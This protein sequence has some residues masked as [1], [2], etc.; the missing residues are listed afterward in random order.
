M[1]CFFDNFSRLLIDYSTYVAR[2]ITN[3]NRLPAG[4]SNS[5]EH[6]Y[7]SAAYQRAFAGGRAA[8][9]LGDAKE[10]GVLD[11]FLNEFIAGSVITDVDAERF[12]SI[13]D[14]YNNS[15][16]RQ[17]S[18]WAIENSDGSVD[19]I[20]RL[21]V[22]AYNRGGLIVERGGLF[23]RDFKQ[24]DGSYVSIKIDMDGIQLDSS[25]RPMAVY[26]G[27][28][29]LPGSSSDD[30]MPPDFDG[31]PNPRESL[32]RLIDCLTEPLRGFRNWL[33]DLFG[34]IFFKIDPLLLDLDLGGVSLT[35][36]SGS[37]VYFDLDSN[38]FAERTGWVSAGEGLLALDGNRNG[39]ID[40]GNELFGG[41]TQ[42]GFAALARY[43]ENKDGR[44][45]A[46]DSVW[47][48]LLIWRDANGDGVST[49]AELT[50]IA[51][52]DIGSIS[53]ANRVPRSY[54][55]FVPTR[56]GNQLLGIG[57]YSSATGVS[58][59][60]IA[61]GFNRDLSN[62][63][64]VLPDG[65]EYDPEVFSLP[66]L[67]GY[68]SLPD[69]W[70]AM[71]LDP[72]LKAMV[73]DLMAGNYDDISDLVGRTFAVDEP[74]Y[75]RY[76]F[77][78]D[79]G[80]SY[81]YE[82]SGFDN[83]LARWAGVPTNNVPFDEGQMRL[84]AERMLGRSFEDSNRLFRDI[85]GS[86][87]FHRA[88]Q[89]MSRELATRF[90]VGMAD[91]AENGSALTLFQDLLS[92]AGDGNAP[93]DPAILQ[94]LIDNAVVGAQNPPTLSPFLAQY[95]LLDYDFGT[96][97]I[98]GDIAGY[99]DAE[100]QAFNFDPD[101]SDERQVSK[102]LSWYNARGGVFRLIDP[103]GSILDER[104]RV[105]TGN[106]YLSVFAAAHTT[107]SGTAGND[108]I[109]GAVRVFLD[110][111]PQTASNVII[112]G[113]GNDLLLGGAG[114]DA[115]VFSDG[116]GQDSVAD[117]SGGA[118]E[119]AFQGSLVSSLAQLSY[120]GTGRRDLLITFAGRTESVLI[121]G[122]FDAAGNATIERITFPDG[123]LWDGQFVRSRLLTQM[124]TAGDDVIRG[125][126]GAETISGGA[127][128]DIL[129]Y[130]TSTDD[131]A[132]D[133]FIGG[134]GND[135]LRGADGNDVY[136]FSRGDGH[137]IVADAGGADI[138]KFDSSIS[139]ED[140]SVRGSGTDVILRINGVDQSIRLSNFL[141]S[142]YQS[143]RAS[144]ANGV[145]WS[146]NELLAMALAGTAGDDLLFADIDGSTL[147]GG[148]GNDSLS[149]YIDNDIL[150]GG[151]GNDILSGS[152]GSNFY[153]FSRG[154]GHDVVN[155]GR[156]LTA[157]IFRADRDTISFDATITPDDVIVSQGNG[158]N[159]LILRIA[160]ED[161]S[162]TIANFLRAVDETSVRFLN[163]T[164]WSGRQL[165]ALAT[166]ATAGDDNFI[167]SSL[168]DTL[169]GGAGNDR[170][171][172]NASDDILSGGDGN[173]QLIGGFG[174]D[175]LIGGQGD[176]E[177]SGSF[178]NNIYK[179]SSGDG[180]DV[181]NFGNR[182]D[183]IEFDA[184][185]A[186]SN[187]KVI[188]SENNQDLILQINGTAQSI[189][190]R[191]AFLNSRFAANE[192]R[193]T[194]GTVLTVDDLSTLQTI[195]T[196]GDDRLLGIL[197]GDALSGG[198]GNDRIIGGNADEIITGGT[199][200]DLLS[201]GAGNNIFRFGQ[202]DGH[203]RIISGSA[204]AL[205]ANDVLEFSAGILQSN[206]TGSF[207]EDGKEITLLIAGMQD[208][209]TIGL[210]SP[211]IQNGAIRFADGTIWGASE[212]YAL[213]N[214]PTLG[215]DVLYTSP[216]GGLIQGFA[217]NDQ[218]IGE[219]G[220]DILIGGE[221]ND[222]LQG[223]GNSDTYRFS[224]GDG[225]DTI[226]EESSYIDDGIYRFAGTN[227]IE[228]GS[229]INP[230]DV[231]A[232]W[233]DDTQELLIRFKNS[234]DSIRIAGRAFDPTLGQ[235]TEL[236]ESNQDSGDYPTDRFDYIAE[237]RFADGTIWTG[238]DLRNNFFAVYGNT[239]ELQAD[240]DRQIIDTGGYFTTAIGD[241]GNNQFVYQRGYGT[242]EIDQTLSTSFDPSSDEIIPN[243]SS[244]NLGA[245]I[246]AADVEVELAE[247][248][249]IIL[250]IGD[251]DT[252]TLLGARFTFRGIDP[253]ATRIPVN[254]VAS[255]HFADGT[256]WQYSDLLDR[257]F[258]GNS[259]L[260]SIVS[261]DYGTI[262]D[263]KGFA[264]TIISRGN[265]DTIIYNQGYGLVEIT[266]ESPEP[267]SR[268]L[269][270]V[271]SEIG[272]P[273]T[274]A[275]DSELLPNQIQ[276][277]SGLLLENA[278]I[279]IINDQTLVI[280]FGGGDVIEIVGALNTNPETNSQKDIDLFRFSDGSIFRFSE[281]IARANQTA[282]TGGAQL[283]GEPITLYGNYRDQAFDSQGIAHRILTGGGQDEIIYNR[284]YGE[285]VIESIN[286]IADPGI[287][288]PDSGPPSGNGEFTPILI[289]GEATTYISFGA[290]IGQ[291]DL[292]F[293]A[294]NDDVHIDLG[295][296]DKLIL[297]N[298]LMDF[299]ILDHL[300]AN[301]LTLADTIFPPEFSL[302]FADGSSLE[303]S[304]IAL[305][306]EQNFSPAFEAVN[307]AA[308]VNEQLDA[309]SI[310]AVG[311]IGFTD[312]NLSDGHTAAITQVTASG[313]SASVLAQEE[314]L[315]FLSADIDREDALD[316]SG[317]VR[318]LFLAPQSSLDFLANGE[319]LTLQYTLSLND[320]R[321]EAVTRNIIVNI[322]GTNDIPQI[323][324]ADSGQR[325]IPE[326][327]SNPISGEID[328]GDADITDTHTARVSNV[329]VNGASNPL[330]D[331]VT[332]RGW[333]SLQVTNSQD[334]IAQTGNLVSWTFAADTSVF[335][336]LSLSEIVQITY[337]I[338]ISDGNGGI[339]IHPVTF[340]ITG[341]T[342]AAGTLLALN[343]TIFEED[344]LIDVR[345]PT[346]AFSG[347][348]SGNILYTARMADGEGLPQ[349][350]NFDGTRFTGTPPQNFNGVLAIRITASNG[351]TAASDVFNL[352]IEAVNDSPIVSVSLQDRTFS[353]ISA[354]DFILPANAFTDVDG[355]DLELFAT[356]ANGS[357]LPDW[358][359]FIDGRFIGMPPSDFADSLDIAVIASDG[360]F[361]V[362][363]VFRLSIGLANT[364][365]SAMIALLEQQFDE[366]G[367][368][369]IALPVNSFT[370]IDGD[371]IVI[372]AILSDGN[373]LP[374]WL[375]FDGVNFTGTPPLNFFGELN[376]MVTAHDGS[377]STSQ[378]FV[379]TILAVNDAP[380][381][382]LAIATQIV[383][384]GSIFTFVVPNASFVD[385]DAD[386]LTLS[387]SLAGGSALPSWLSFDGSA[388]GGT[389]PA[390]YSGVLALVITASDGN[391]EISQEFTLSVVPSNTAP[392]LVAA[393]S[394]VIIDEDVALAFAL[395][396]NMFSDIDGDAL[397][398]T[399]NLADG[400]A[401]PSWLT[402]NAGQFTGTAPLNYNGV[403]DIAVTASDGV[404]L[405]SDQ[406]RLT[407]SAINDAPVAS[408]ALLARHFAEDQL[409]SFDLPA[410]AFTDVDG[411][412]LSVTATLGDGSV[413]PQWLT[414]DGT[415]F[416][417][418]PPVNFNGVLEI[419]VTA[420]DGSASASQSFNLIIDASN[421][422]P[423]LV[424]AIADVVSLEDTAVNFVL[425]AGMFAD[426]DGDALTLSATLADGNPLPAWLSLSG[427]IFTGQPPANFNGVLDI[428]VSA[429]DGGAN[430]NDQFRLTINPVNDAPV[431]LSALADVHVGEDM[432]VDILIPLAT[433]GDADNAEL[434]VS[435]SLSDGSALPSWL[436]YTNGRLTGTPPANFFS[437][438]EIR[439]TASDGDLSASESFSLIIDPVNDTPTLANSIADAA[440][441]EDQYI[442]ILLPAGTFT[443]LDGDAL[444][445]TAALA[446]GAA[447]PAWLSFDGLRFTGQAPA[448]FNGALEITVS[449]SDGALS[450]TDSYVLTV[451]AVN[452]RPTLLAALADAVRSEDTSIDLLLPMASFA[453]VDGDALSFT[454]RLASGE[455]LP[456]WLV[457]N[458]ARFTGTPPLNYNGFA[459]IEITAS[460]GSLQV[461]DVFRLTISAEQDAPVLTQL[462]ADVSVT[463][464]SAFNVALPAGTFTDV[465]ADN[466]TLSARL[467]N[468]AA[469]PT[470]INFNGSRF[471]GTPPADFSGFYDIEVSASDGTS[472]ISDIFRFTIAAVN[473]APIV[474]AALV[475]RNVAEDTAIDFMVPAGSFIDADN[476]ALTYTAALASG[477]ALPSWLTFDASSQRFTGTPPVNF[478]GYVDVRVT[479]SD[480]TLSASDD[481]RLTVTPINDAPVAANDGGLN[482]VAGSALVVQ[483]AAL[484]ANDNDVDGDTLTIT[485]V[486]GAVGGT[487]ILNA[488]GQIIY[489]A[490]AGYVGIGS[491]VYTISDGALTSSATASVQVAAP[492]SPW[493][494]GTSGNDN[495][496]GVQNAVNWIDGRAGDDVI[497][498]GALNDHMVGGSGNDKLYAGS[499]N[500]LLDGGDGNDTIT[501][502]AGDDVLNGGAGND[503][504]YAGLGDD[505][506][507]AGD[508]DDTVT[509]DAGNDIISGGLG[510][511]LLYA[512]A[513]NDNID[514]G[515]G[516]DTIT[517]DAG[518]DVLTGGSGNDL[519]YAGLGNDTL[520]G[521]DGTDKLYG[522]DGNDSL[523]GGAGNDTIDGG[524]GIDTA[525]YSNA[526]SAWTI[527]LITNAASSGTEAD[528]IYNMENILAGSGND[529]LTGSN[530]ANTLSG[531]AGN[532]RLT[533]GLG[534]DNLAGGAGFDIAV[535]AGAISTYSITTVNGTITVTDNAPTA[536]GN[537]G[538]DTI[539]G[540][541]QL[542]FSGGASI[543]I[544]APII[545]DLDG[546][547]VRTVSAATSNARYDLDGDG[548]TDDTSWIGNTEGFLFLDRDSNGTV[549]N[550]GEFSF[551]DDVAGAK[552][553]LEGLKAFD[554]NND[555]IL[556]ALDTR[557]SEFRVWQ[558]RDG[559]G[560]A[561]EGEI[562]SLTTAGVRSIN[563]T[564]TA[565]TAT[566][567][568][569]EVAVINRGSYTRTSGAAMEFLDAALT[570]F[571]SATTMPTLQ[572][573][574][575]ELSR[576]AKKYFISFAGGEMQLTP[577]KKKGEI[578]ARAGALGASSMLTFKNKSYGMLSTIILDL[579]GDGIEMRSIKR[580]SAAFDMNGDGVA[581]DTGWV[582]R[583]DGLLVIDRNNDGEINNVSEL[584]LA[585][586]D[587]DANSAMEALA[588]L[589]NNNDRVIDAKDVRFGELKVWIDANGNGVTDAGE[590]KTLEEV[591]I[592]SINLA[593]RNLEGQADTG[594]NILLST[595]TFRRS[596]GSTGTA[597]NAVL[598]YTPGNV[599]AGAERT[600]ALVDALRSNRQRREPSLGY[601]LPLN[602]DP[603]AYFGEGDSRNVRAY[604]GDIEPPPL[605]I[606]IPPPPIAAATT[607]NSDQLLA[608]ITQEMATFGARRGG[609]DNPL[610]G[611]NLVQPLDYFG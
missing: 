459:D 312:Q 199:G 67:R 278:T 141:S 2:G 61:I 494:Y 305:L 498:G 384:A 561:E 291:E 493:V 231:F 222:L 457:F 371:T 220:S 300:D 554:S 271:E 445:I 587:A 252:V 314:L 219:D 174:N 92:A 65:F 566:S 338:E 114:S 25:D 266:V 585:S 342:D 361:S 602:I 183:I 484:L 206:I 508:G 480:G 268:L 503:L 31:V 529:V 198:D 36:L 427:G 446:S 20:Q 549:T 117:A 391:A 562:L 501:G 202:G 412:S 598:A 309:N 205:N 535:F 301:G 568:L 131:F 373:T 62:T 336:V 144:F 210:D 339:V 548:L 467:A 348:L 158:G 169:Q 540:I 547:G 462:L 28:L 191:D 597:G 532:D 156:F 595:A 496:Y 374:D 464:D 135:T 360:E 319:V 297:R 396:G 277:G 180:H 332:V 177:L 80:I 113:A 237:Y 458:G 267:F 16:G 321:S 86:P 250:N 327:L 512:G 24:E 127:G 185:I 112:G 525:D 157:T 541:E 415:R 213:A 109:E 17:I 99:I 486:S 432:P 411:D 383:S 162:I 413:L 333:L 140:V 449:A 331:L 203:D 122:Y 482:A 329:R 274:I 320:G 251:G 322:T 55:S 33:G 394:D 524:A 605:P 200:N 607:N 71:S 386:I 377:L 166:T 558:D 347:V 34:N 564:G 58:A 57:S 132:G 388:F 442:N 1:T 145:V 153:R 404:S 111:R 604:D 190:L 196:N 11:A 425:P 393:A 87:S 49:A 282:L 592:T 193:F 489:T 129:G 116:S 544:A 64:F 522:D 258:S 584:S 257:F 106:Q 499:G 82:A 429:S 242:L 175:T 223:R 437:N 345:L 76:G 155:N 195:S 215:D 520:N 136:R 517:G 95:A 416:S 335:S 341:S 38:G 354:L 125:T 460:D 608:L 240:P 229:G 435:A 54:G 50:P 308:N 243:T 569:G 188:V 588:A 233:A 304:D 337:D 295:N 253:V 443:D 102:Y 551:I 580:A 187:I 444:T 477:A 573:Q 3:G 179:F 230:E 238:E 189:T 481:F 382:N 241:G 310:V 401:L 103:N 407:I 456:S 256:I 557:F 39:R 218:L 311:N 519:I 408:I 288:V 369:N 35:S 48:S 410:G 248:G 367:A 349:W 73:Q 403:I 572:V 455:P 479:A 362:T 545:L 40:N 536:N 465:D 359:N 26:P 96:D 165:F 211:L 94:Q 402:F 307:V 518:N 170:L 91:I 530:I 581:D 513:G 15:I 609:N 262:I 509:G 379:L 511:D 245:G 506:I 521:G 438:F 8:V 586:E 523:S 368:I 578:D 235:I 270:L 68:G 514:G 108:T 269:E 7:A 603:F 364:A 29:N 147:S 228:F 6:A 399:A 260:S 473:D 46:D 90:V 42:N 59:E 418:T 232:V 214:G 385:S 378:E 292:R 510:N 23:F 346:G 130:T 151:R 284:G 570:Y 567:A 105:Y 405:V 227:R 611:R 426:L 470:W 216:T 154:D 600:N 47:S 491:F 542:Q 124:A 21:I 461:S 589:D 194:D 343:G 563:L 118:D 171:M 306:V 160:G 192:I 208:S 178:E 287:A 325:L 168:A 56:A 81:H 97:E 173:D 293:F 14:Q 119:V 515:S 316:V 451:S 72:V 259:N 143:F 497:T 279:S 88:L 537:D 591:G 167:G 330:I 599:L 474:T 422:A 298:F 353:Q 239:N 490:N 121:K 363:E 148:D 164:I 4:A 264:R 571:S 430:A 234:D 138:I 476:I 315:S 334:P 358:L 78:R 66:N 552:S 128:N 428:V 318:W 43:D 488:Q 5:L 172:G 409:V 326:N 516:N 184:S 439:I 10:A 440:V 303:N 389:P 421:D 594:K 317:N 366:D 344:G 74:D 574:E 370:D 400:S 150:I 110:G 390:N 555:G 483:A 323:I 226:T 207:S 84:V 9:I 244:L 22:D 500:D 468:G 538:T 273:P 376:I 590:L 559:D 37:N 463:E 454:A 593:M 101:A 579:D 290:D 450:V 556:S 553:D 224:G 469:L 201:G 18:D 575:M 27:P 107:Q 565:V 123:P 577:T 134:T 276:F 441:S 289:Y 280:D 471:T 120:A 387:A 236:P 246:F 357:A 560:A 434:A 265:L 436:S 32:H 546:N 601:E 63:R 152:S 272:L 475:D 372:T 93:I 526:T 531:G 583:D 392:T 249:D 70:V 247:N 115:Y 275:A 176:D 53:L 139:P 197:S 69:L 100:L 30:F 419:A 45:T 159:S 204:N 83:M 60:A 351:T 254:G 452:D 13:K 487:A 255:V 447:L 146:S 283:G 77:L 472:I 186:L 217:G 89:Q 504:L 505:N 181:V 398:I 286:R 182:L 417:G 375:S 328:F 453:D 606:D 285:L 356:L 324:D 448:N 209:V 431:V 527:N 478:N 610:N 507:N 502:E 161:Q 406:F 133:V 380:V 281:L 19:T 582:G 420:A 485:G 340:T 212:I 75:Y 466:L 313:I 98:G 142:S 296:G 221:G 433:F 397:L 495:L 381:A 85:Q 294:V 423:E 414:F 534:N 104:L 41:A 52:N 424:S 596:N 263:P 149:G 350:L 299:D 225:Q 79:G 163:G 533:G 550:A 12:D 576:K 44:I 539:T 126:P 395:P 543:N 137:D 261:D 355:T 302:E 365:P 528:I 51:A 352:E 492:S